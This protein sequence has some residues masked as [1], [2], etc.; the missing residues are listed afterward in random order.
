MKIIDHASIEFNF[1]L[2]NSEILQINISFVMLR[3][4]ESQPLE[5]RDDEYHSDIATSITAATISSNNV[6][7]RKSN[8]PFFHNLL[9][10]R[11]GPYA[12]PLSK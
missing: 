3:V 8:H 6:N 9:S 12:E 10:L 2:P 11:P 4:K 7:D 1:F 5:I